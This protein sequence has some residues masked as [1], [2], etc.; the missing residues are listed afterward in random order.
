MSGMR[1]RKGTRC[2]PCESIVRDQAAE[3]DDAAVLDQHVGVDRALVG[4]QVHGALR[5]LRE[6]RA[7][8][9]DLQHHRIAV[10]RA[11]LRRHLEDR[12]DFLALNGLEGIDGAV[13]V[14]PVLV[15]WPVTNG[16]SCATLSSASWLSMVIVEGVAMML[17]S[18][19]PRMARS[20]APKFTPV[21]ADAA[22]AEG[23]AVAELPGSR[24]SGS[25]AALTQIDE[26][27]P[28]DRVQEPADGNARVVIASNTAQLT[29][30]SEVLSCD[31]ST[32]MAS[33][34]T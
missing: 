15:N 12:A 28:P 3:H 13:L 34:S 27:A 24:R 19:S 23:R 26:A 32:M 30:S 18:L 4:D 10:V 31:T 17:L 7:L 8:Q 2:S 21:V 9:L 33:T 16:T 20:I 1:P 22:D 29:P 14:P 5:A 6:A 25:S 11:D